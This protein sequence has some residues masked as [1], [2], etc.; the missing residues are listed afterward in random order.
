MN[1]TPECIKFRADLFKYAGFA[2]MSPCASMLYM[3]V[4]EQDYLFNDFSLSCFL[5]SLFPAFLGYNFLTHA[6]T[7]LDKYYKGESS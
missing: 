4:T 7:I 6:V 1:S 3:V 2:L 5:L